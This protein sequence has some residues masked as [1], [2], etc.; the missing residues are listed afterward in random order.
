MTL[1]VDSSD[2]TTS[3]DVATEFFASGAVPGGRYLHA[4]RGL[5]KQRNVGLGEVRDLVDV[6]HFIDDDVELDHDYLAGL[7]QALERDPSLVGV[8]GMVLGG[9]RGRPSRPA[10]LTGRDSLTP[11]AVTRMGFNVGAHETPTPVDVE[12]LPGCSMSFRL[13]AINGL[14]FDESREGYAIGEDVD[15][16]LKA[17]ARGRL[18]HVPTARLVHHLSAV[19]RHRRAELTRMAVVHRWA[20]ARDQLGSVTKVGVIFGTLAECVT[21][22]LKGIRHRRVELF[23]LAWADILGL[24]DALAGSSR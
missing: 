12:W 3:Q 11:G 1:I 19:N 5:T 2:T 9:N 8:G 18:Q 4:Q 24:R 23:G 22:F 14:S 13:S 6:V 17:S 10:L 16:G 7:M 20:L 15:F 21:Y